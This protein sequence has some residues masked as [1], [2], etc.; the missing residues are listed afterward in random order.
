M[1]VNYK[2]ATTVVMSFV[3]ESVKKLGLIAQTDFDRNSHT[4]K[5]TLK[6]ARKMC[7]VLSTGLTLKAQGSMTSQ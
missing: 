6:W 5:S 7:S 2:H 3:S 1:Q 4:N